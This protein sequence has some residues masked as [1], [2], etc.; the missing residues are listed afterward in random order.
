MQAYNEL[1]KNQ[2]FQESVRLRNQN[3]STSGHKFR[4]QSKDPLRLNLF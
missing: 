3:R 2:L 4:A 1:T